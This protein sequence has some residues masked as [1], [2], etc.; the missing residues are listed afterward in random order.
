MFK[1]LQKGYSVH[2]LE[3][4]DG[5]RYFCGTVALVSAPRYENA[6]TNPMDFSKLPYDKVIDLTV[7]YDG[8]SKTFVVPETSNVQSSS[9]FTLSCSPEFIANELNAVIKNSTSIIESVDHHKQ[10]ISQCKAVLKEVDRN[11]AKESENNER[12]ERIEKT[13]DRLTKLLEKK[14]F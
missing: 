14:D 5:I 9:S 1:D 12:I 11:Y 6:P 7:E 4:T 8:K 10:L 2:V 3:K 13:L